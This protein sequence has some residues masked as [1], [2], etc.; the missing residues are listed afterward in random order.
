MKNKGNIMAVFTQEQRIA[1]KLVY[2][3]RICNLR[4]DEVKKGDH[5]VIREVVEHNGGVVIAC[6]PEPGLVVLVKQYRYPLNRELIELPAGRLE[7]G[8]IPLDA[9]KR[10]LKEE[11]GYSASSWLDLCK[12]YSAP[13]FCDEL[14]HVYRAQNVTLGDK[15]P[16]HDEETEVIVIPVKEAWQRVMSGQICDAKTIAGIAMLI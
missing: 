11:T 15:M 10:E 6:Q 13:G 12:M 3:G 1:S 7:K 8:E 5:T 14:L 2:Q 4:V 9:A 16:D